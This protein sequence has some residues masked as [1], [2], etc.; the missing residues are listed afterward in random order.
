MKVSRRVAFVLAVFAVVI[1][2][3]VLAPAQEDQPLAPVPEGW[4]SVEDNLAIMFLESDSGERV[5]RL[6]IL[7][8]GVWLPL[9][10]ESMPKG[11]EFLSQ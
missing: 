3:G 5:G 4:L 10:L 6:M 2:L 7:E 1:T 11:I 8:N 9:Y